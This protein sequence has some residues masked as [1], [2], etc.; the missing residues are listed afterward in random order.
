MS[1]LVLT[2]H[3]AGINN[4]NFLMRDEQ[5]GTYWQ[6]ISGRAISVSSARANRAAGTGVTWRG[7]LGVALVT[8]LLV[9]REGLEAVFY[10]GVQSMALRASQV[11]AQAVLVVVGAV[12]GLIASGLLAWYW[13]RYS[14]RLQLGIVLKVTAIFLGLSPSKTLGSRSRASLSLVTLA[15]HLRP[16][17]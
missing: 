6:Q 1:G 3:L 4:Q 9:T 5:T 12:L 11:P 7:V 8:L 17:R 15:D 10:L 16:L 13:S 14:H 2:F